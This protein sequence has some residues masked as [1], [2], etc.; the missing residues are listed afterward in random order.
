ML[1][2]TFVCLFVVVLHLYFSLSSPILLK[3][4]SLL[5]RICTKKRHLLFTQDAPNISLLS[6]GKSHRQLCPPVIEDDVI[7][8]KLCKKENCHLLKC[9][10]IAAWCTNIK[11]KK[12]ADNGIFIFWLPLLLV[13]TQSLIVD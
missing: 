5:K 12:S 11:V 8:R 2:N 3:S 4:G 6:I 13:R 7:G 10:Q 9:L 1:Y